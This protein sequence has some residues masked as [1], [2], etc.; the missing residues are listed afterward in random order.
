VRKK[1]WNIDWK[2]AKI[3][4]E[5]SKESRGENHILFIR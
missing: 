4:E 5:K 1:E 3:Q 2:E